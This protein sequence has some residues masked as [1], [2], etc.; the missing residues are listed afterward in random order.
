MSHYYYTSEKKSNISGHSDDSSAGD[1]VH[2]RFCNTF[3][4]KTH[5]NTPDPDGINALNWGSS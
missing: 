2:K 4:I 5:M 1:R 3:L